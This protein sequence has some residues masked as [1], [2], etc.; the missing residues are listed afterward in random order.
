MDAAVFG[1]RERRV[2]QIKLR[3][4][5]LRLR[6]GDRRVD[7][8]DLGSV[9]QSGAVHFRFRLGEGRHIDV[10]TSPPLLCSVAG[11]G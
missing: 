5:E 11:C 4:E 3:L 2:L 1:R 6:S 10:H 8:A 9:F 7:A